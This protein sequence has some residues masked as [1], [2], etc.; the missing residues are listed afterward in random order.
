MKRFCIVLNDG[1]E[2]YIDGVVSKTEASKEAI[3]RGLMTKD[4]CFD[5]KLIT[6]VGDLIINNKENTKHFNDKPKTPNYL[7]K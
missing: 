2:I 3:K 1:T 7:E 6:E 4:D 5:I